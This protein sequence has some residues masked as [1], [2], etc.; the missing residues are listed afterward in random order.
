MSGIGDYIH[1]HTENYKKFGTTENGPSNYDEAG[2][3]L[4][5]RRKKMHD[6]AKSMHLKYSNGQIEDLERFMNSIFYPPK[7]GRNDLEK[8]QFSQMK[9]Y[10]ESEFEKA[11]DDFGINWEQGMSVYVKGKTGIGKGTQVRTLQKVYNQLESAFARVSSANTKAKIEQAKQAITDALDKLAQMNIGAD[12]QVTIGKNLE[13]SEDLIATVNNALR[14]TMYNNAAVGY[15]FELALAAFSGQMSDRV[16]EIAA[17]TVNAA[18]QGAVRSN[19]NIRI[20]LIDKHFFDEELFGREINRGRT[21]LGVWQRTEDGTAFQFTAP[22]QDKLDVALSFDGEMYNITAKNYANITQ[23]DIHIVSGTSLLSMILDDDVD[24]INHYLNITATDEPEKTGYNLTLAHQAMKLTILLKSLSGIGTSATGSVADVLVVND[25]A[26][27]HIYIRSV[28]DLV[29]K[30]AQQ[31]D[32]ID[33]YMKIHG[34]GKGGTLNIKNDYV[35]TI[36]SDNDAQ[37]RITKLLAQLHNTKISVSLKGTALT[38][39]TP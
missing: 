39:L 11:F 34:L 17:D 33:E 37:I 24:F 3:S 4:E 2:L 25:R 10:V 1:Y 21:N 5:R 29:G 14:A 20:D 22:T 28:G 35:G 38:D 18:M 27:K 36:P 7:N 30:I 6:L 12:A 19:P 15:I 31:L 9:R 13:H 8:E 32:K 16:G 23:R 26:S